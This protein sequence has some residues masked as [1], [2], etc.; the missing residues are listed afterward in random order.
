MIDVKNKTQTALQSLTLVLLTSLII[1]DTTKDNGLQKAMSASLAP[2]NTNLTNNFETLENT[3]QKFILDSLAPI[4]IKL[5]STR[6]NNYERNCPPIVCEARPLDFQQT[7]CSPDCTFLKHMSHDITT[8][9]CKDNSQCI[10]RYVDGSLVG[11]HI[12][13]MSEMCFE[14]SVTYEV[15]QSHCTPLNRL[16]RV[17][18]D[19]TIII[20]NGLVIDKNIFK[21]L[22]PQPIP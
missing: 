22:C 11:V 2:I 7:V 3:L 5:D 10:G 18:P 17:C 4:N 9:I 12:F 1:F 6:K 21:R 19:S 13:N 15:E 14:R 16:V 8:H 20:D